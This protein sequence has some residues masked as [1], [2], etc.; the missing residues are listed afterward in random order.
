MTEE[1]MIK[2]EKVLKRSWKVDGDELE[3]I[4]FEEDSFE[5]SKGDSDFEESEGDSD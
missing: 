5:E 3:A 1:Q 4:S 2:R